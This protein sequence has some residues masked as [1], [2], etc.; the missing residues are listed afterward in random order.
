MV[1]DTG[2]IRLMVKVHNVTGQKYLCKSERQNYIEYRG[3]G[4][5]WIGHLKE[6]GVDFS[7]IVLY[8]TEN[9]KDFKRVA[10]LISTLFDVVKRSD[11][12]HKMHENGF[13]G[14]T[15]SCKIWITNGEKELYHNKEDPI[16][17]GWRR[18]RSHNCKFKD[19][20]FQASLTNRIDRTTEKYKASRRIAVAKTLLV[21]DHSKCGTKGDKN[22]AKRLEVRQ[23]ISN[24]I[25]PEDRQRRSDRMKAFHESKRKN[26]A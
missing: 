24:S 22:P 4:L 7:T 10:L 25:T 13:G 1:V 23:K 11:F 19:K 20:I 8:E 2:M 12:S 5:K 17:E 21:R 3:S 16:P 15:V 9:K 26:K 6:H 14:D 18:G